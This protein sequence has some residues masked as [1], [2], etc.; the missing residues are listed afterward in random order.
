MTSPITG[1]L[2]TLAGLAGNYVSH[3]I[4]TPEG[5]WVWNVVSHYANH[6]A[7]FTGLPSPITHVIVD[8]AID[9][10]RRRLSGRGA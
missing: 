7:R 1:S 8:A 9:S 3:F 4:T 5:D 6:A 2:A 10:M